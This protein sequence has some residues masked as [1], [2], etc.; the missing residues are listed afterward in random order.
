MLISFPVL[1]KLAVERRPRK[2]AAEEIDL[3]HH[4]VE[5]ATDFAVFA[6]DGSGNVV[7]WNVGAERLIGYSEQEIVGQSGDVIFTPEDR[8]SGAPERERTQAAQSGRS[9]D[10]RW[11]QR[12]DG[13]G[14]PVS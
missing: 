11:H 5:S 10:E 8:S 9:E 6:Q 2:A 4:I 1:R 14:D 7:T 3:F 12:K 13:S